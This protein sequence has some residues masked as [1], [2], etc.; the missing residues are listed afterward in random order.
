MAPGSSATTPRH[1]QAPVS[2]RGLD[3][4]VEF[5]DAG[6][7]LE[8]ALGQATLGVAGQGKSDLVPAD[9]DA[10]RALTQALGLSL[11]PAASQGVS[12]GA[13]CSTYSLGGLRWP[14]MGRLAL[15]S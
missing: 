2:L 10:Q 5:L 14:V 3:G 7:Q 4:L 12:T 9:V 6:G 11:R 8:I 1:R 13:E 15:A